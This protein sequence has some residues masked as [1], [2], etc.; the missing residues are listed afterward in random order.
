MSS[1]STVI[2]FSRAACDLEGSMRSCIRASK[3]HGSATAVK[4]AALLLLCSLRTDFLSDG[5]KPL[6]AAEIFL[7]EDGGSSW[8][9][10]SLSS[11]K[12]RR[13]GGVDN[14]QLQAT[15]TPCG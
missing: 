10:L 2:R 3:Q 4:I 11:Q 14:L 8:V 13:R 6:A 15:L 5:Q 1:V 12:D 9:S 7:G